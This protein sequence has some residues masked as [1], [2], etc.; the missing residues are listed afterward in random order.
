MMNTINRLFGTGMI[1]AAFFSGSSSWALTPKHDCFSFHN[2]D[3]E[4][5]ALAESYLL[6]ALDREAL[7]TFVGNLKPISSGFASFRFPVGQEP[8]EVKKARKI[9]SHFTCGNAYTAFVQNYAFISQGKQYADTVIVAN[10]LLDRTVESYSDVFDQLAP[11]GYETVRELLNK[12]EFGERYLRYEAYGHLFGY[13]EYAVDFYVESARHQDSTGE[14]VKRVFVSV[15]TF[16][17]REGHFVWAAP[18]GHLEN[19]VDKKIKQVANSI[20]QAYTERRQL[21]IEEQGLTASALL[22][23]WFCKSDHDC[24]SSYAEF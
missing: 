3:P 2:L 4:L 19:A 15:P 20:L 23:S 11:E 22:Q 21:Y 18:V 9:L 16:S 13:P 6:Q 24:D 5:R 10:D 12:V 7:Y 8:E 17:A 1:L 14:F